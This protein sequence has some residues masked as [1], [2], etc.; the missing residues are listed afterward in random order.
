MTRLQ[1]AKKQLSEALLAL[2]SAA[3]RGLKAPNDANS[4]PKPTRMLAQDD[5][6]S[7]LSALVDEVSIIEAKLNEAIS[8]I[9]SV[10][11]NPVRPGATD[12]GDN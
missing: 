2:E 3:S 4:S 7:D 10:E 11:H 12:D 6:G 9:D 5:T 8:M 1:N